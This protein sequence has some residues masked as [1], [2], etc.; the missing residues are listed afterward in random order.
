M[1]RHHDE[2]KRQGLTPLPFLFAFTQICFCANIVTT[3]A[4]RRPMAEGK[5]ITSTFAAYARQ[6][7]SGWDGIGCRISFAMTMVLA[8]IAA[9][10]G[11]FFLG[12]VKKISISKYGAEP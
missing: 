6:V 1:G 2:T 7:T 5:S 8:P 3:V 10:S 12:T 4:P 11:M 9:L